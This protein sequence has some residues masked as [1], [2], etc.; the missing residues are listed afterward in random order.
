[1][2][3]ILSLFFISKAKNSMSFHPG[4]TIGVAFLG[5]KVEISEDV[6]LH[7]AIL[8]MGMKV[9]THTRSLCLAVALHGHTH[10]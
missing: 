10:A 9:L 6:S 4:Q 5:T 2:Q 8:C 1:M 7:S 3:E